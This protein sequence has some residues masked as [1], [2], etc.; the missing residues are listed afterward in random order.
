MPKL[1]VYLNGLRLDNANQ[2]VKAISQVTTPIRSDNSTIAVYAL[3]DG[4]KAAELL[5]FEKEPLHAF[6]ARWKEVSPVSDLLG[7]IPS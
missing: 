6:K 5:T 7:H 1:H 3:H 4:L 2:L